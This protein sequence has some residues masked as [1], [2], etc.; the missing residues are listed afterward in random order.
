MSPERELFVVCPHCSNEVSP[1]VTECP[2]CGQR[3]RKRAPDLKKQRKREQKAAR[4]RKRSER[5]RSEPRGSWLEGAE[6][7]PKATIALVATSIVASVLASGIGFT[8]PV[9]V[10]DNLVWTGDA[11]SAPWKLVTAPFLQYSFGAALVCLGLFAGFGAGIERRFGAVA[12]VALW[13]LCGVLG[14]AAE[15]LISSV[16]LGFGAY[17]AAV[18]TVLA[19]TIV[20]VRSEDPAQIDRYAL[21][22][23]ALVLCALPLASSDARLGMLLGGV[24]GGL[25][26]GFALT[27]LPRRG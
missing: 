12:V 11:A 27:L 14:L 8:V 10:F 22:A 4:R 16:P 1:Y 2:Y 20:V 18:G 19:W 7:A 9:W 24:C 25:L 26:G 21:A 5:A 23:V 3:L 17:A 15:S 13:L 6:A